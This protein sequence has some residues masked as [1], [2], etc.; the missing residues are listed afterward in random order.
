MLAIGGYP[1]DFQRSVSSPRTCI[2]ADHYVYPL[3]SYVIIVHGCHPLTRAGFAYLHI[4]SSVLLLVGSRSLD[5]H[6]HGLGVSTSKRDLLPVAH[7]DS[8]AVI[9]LHSPLHA[10]KSFPPHLSAASCLRFTHVLELWHRECPGHQQCLTT[11]N[12]R[13][14]QQC[15]SRNIGNSASVGRLLSTRR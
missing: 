9:M 5:R 2:N 15:Y 3:P 14:Q 8:Y 6:N 10:T 13:L 7:C 1:L 11:A 4:S 12:R